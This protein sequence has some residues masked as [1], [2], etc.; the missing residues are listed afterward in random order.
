MS[1]INFIGNSLLKTDNIY[2]VFMNEKMADTA[3][4]YHSS[5]DEYCPTPLVSLP[6]LAEKLGIG[7]INVKDESHRFGLNAFKVLGSSFAVGNVFAKQFNRD[8]SSITCSM[9]KEKAAK[10]FF[11]SLTLYTA[12]DGN[13]GRGLAWT[14]KTFG[15]KCVVRM[16][17]GT[18]FERMN[19]IK[20][21]G[22]VVTIEDKVY[23]DCVK[24][25]FDEAN[26]DR[27]GILV[28]DTACKEYKDIPLWIMQGYLTMAKEISDNLKSAPTHIFVQAGVGSLA[29]AVAGYFSSVYKNESPKIVVVEPIGAPCHFESA[30]KGSIKRTE[31]ELSTV[32][33]GLACG[34]PNFIS[35]DIL[36]NEAFGF[37][38]CSDDITALGMRILSSPV[39]SDKRVI[40]GES[41]GV[42]MGLIYS[43]MSDN[44][45][46]RIKEELN[47]CENS[48]VLLFSTEGATY[49]KGY[50]DI[51]WKGKLF[52]ESIVKGN[53]N[54]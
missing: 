49:S 53:G 2:K 12:T 21:L 18:C 41:A 47:L 23:D 52:N 30:Q 27:N 39:G 33:A 54:D 29:G 45:F 34:E 11:N 1:V 22:A 28:Q 8:I 7:E 10:Q 25:A 46:K 38:T 16:P 17:K 37:I 5:F 43:I 13:H 42:G 4:C 44:K 14:A 48:R 24:M 19:N 3:C 35:W 15:S 6:C 9:M 31:G 32:M 51:V 26:G 36:Q 20:K 50:E 40:S